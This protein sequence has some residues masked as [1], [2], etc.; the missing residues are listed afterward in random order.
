MYTSIV[1]TEFD[2]SITLINLNNN[3]VTEK[4]GKV[5]LTTADIN[6]YVHFEIRLGAS[7][8]V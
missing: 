4:F 7:C 5:W 8:S 3:K 6:V 2:Y 1:R